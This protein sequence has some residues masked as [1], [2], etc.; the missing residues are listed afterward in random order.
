MAAVGSVPLPS[1]SALTSRRGPLPPH[2]HP[3]CRSVVHA[4]TDRTPS[5]HRAD[6]HPPRPRSYSRFASL[7]SADEQG[8]DADDDGD[9]E[10]AGADALDHAARR[11]CGSTTG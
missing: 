11:L 6:L 4:G 8:G 2:A 7:L 3:D 10:H 9:E 1:V 5:R